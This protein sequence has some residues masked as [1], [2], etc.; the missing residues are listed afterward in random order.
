MEIIGKHGEGLLGRDGE[1]NNLSY[2]RGS[3]EWGRG[4]DPFESKSRS[5]SLPHASQVHWASSF[6]HLP[7][8]WAIADKAHKLAS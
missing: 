1:A 7:N 8:E 3:H 4:R 2:V 6:P 5:G